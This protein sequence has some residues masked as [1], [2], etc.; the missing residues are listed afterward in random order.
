MLAK[1]KELEA[2]KNAPATSIPQ[3]LSVKL[4]NETVCTSG[5]INGNHQHDHDHNAHSHSN[6][7]HLEEAHREQD[8]QVIRLSKTKIICLSESYVRLSWA[9]NNLVIIKY[10][11]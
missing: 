3:H 2:V 6:T 4:T 10:K 9:L 7:E 5:H 1:Q 11:L 8:L